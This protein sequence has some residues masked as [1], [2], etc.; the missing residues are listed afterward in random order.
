MQ[1]WRQLARWVTLLGPAPCHSDRRK[2][3]SQPEASHGGTCRQ[4]R[5]DEWSMGSWKGHW[6][7]PSKST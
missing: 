7:P 6:S 4:H 2:K 1:R 3:G 5:P